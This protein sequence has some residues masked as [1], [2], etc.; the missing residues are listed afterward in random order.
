MGDPCVQRGEEGLVEGDA[1]VAFQHR[2]AG[3]DLPVPVA[4][5][6]GDVGDLVAARLA[7]AHGAAEAAEGFEEER[8]HVVR[9]RAAGLGALHVLPHAGHARRIHRVVSER[10]LLRDLDVSL[11]LYC[12]I[13]GMSVVSDPDTTAGGLP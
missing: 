10:L 2:L 13:P 7:P 1:F 5:R 6:G 3:A 9:L 4:D 8:F 12:G 11:Q